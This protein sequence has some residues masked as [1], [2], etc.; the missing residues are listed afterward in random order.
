MILR[1]TLG[2]PRAIQCGVRFQLHSAPQGYSSCH[3]EYM[4][5]LD[6]LFE[7]E[8][9]EAIGRV[10]FGHGSKISVSQY[11]CASPRHVATANVHLSYHVSS[12]CLIS[13]MLQAL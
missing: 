12:N 9:F 6:W 11:R 10:D 7:K 5:V 1:S 3:L 13:K 4:Q 8:Y 2:S